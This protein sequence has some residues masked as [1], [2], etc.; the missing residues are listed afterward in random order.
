MPS[1]SA[2]PPPAVTSVGKLLQAL[3]AQ[4]TPQE[5]SATLIRPA[6]VA[7]ELGC[8]AGAVAVA[9]VFLSPADDAL[10]VISSASHRPDPITLSALLGVPGIRAATEEQ[11]A[12]IT[13]Q[14]PLAVAPVAHPQPLDTMVDVDLSHYDNVWTT[15][16][17]PGWYV[18]TSYAELLRITAGEAAEVGD[19]SP[20]P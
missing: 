5:L 20:R 10:L 9:S 4:G 15:A 16:G 3:G 13:G 19:L 1:Q 14:H 6:T 8:D 12:A 2:S 7:D 17:A 18:E 11:T